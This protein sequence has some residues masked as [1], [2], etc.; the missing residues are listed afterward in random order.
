[1]NIFFVG[2]GGTDAGGWVWTGHGFKRVPGWNPEQLVELT[3]ALK[4]L[5]AARQLKTPGVMEAAGRAVND[6]VQK[7]L[8]TH[9]KEGGI[10]VIG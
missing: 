4:V 8:G 6:L 1:M 3:A 5:G 9:L 2:G 7:E 10:L